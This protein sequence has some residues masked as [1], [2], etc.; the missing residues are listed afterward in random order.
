MQW[1]LRKRVGR[2]KASG[3]QVLRKT[4]LLV[5]SLEER[6]VPTGTWTTLA[7]P[8]P[9]GDG[10]GLMLLQSDGT[11][12]VQGGYDF[13]SSA[14]YKLTPDSTGS[15]LK[16]SWSRLASMHTER[17]DYA[18]NVLP[19]GR[20]FVLGGEYSDPSGDL[21]LTN[22]GEIYDPVA[23]TWTSIP[24][25]PQPVFGDDP[26]EVLPNGQVLVGYKLGPETFLYDPAS[27]TWSATG[28][29]LHND[30]SREE[31]WVKLP[32]DSILSYD[33]TSSLV[34]GTGHAQRY[35]PSLG[36]WVDAG[37]VPVPLSAASVAGDSAGHEIGPA[38]LL[39][40]GRVFCLGASGDTAFYTPPANPTDPGSWVAGPDIPNSLASNDAGG[41][42]LPNGDVL[43]IATDLAGNPRAVLEFNPIASTYTDVTPHNNFPVG[44][45]SKMLVLPTGQ[46]VMANG[47]GQIDVFTPDSGPNPAW[48][49]AIS[50]I[51]DNGNNTFTL[52]GT[53][54]NG[55]S[56]GA[57]FGDDAEMSTNYP[58][59][60][61]TD[62]NG[63]VSYARTYNW[64]STGVATGS[65]PVS[66]QF[67]LPAGAAPGPYLVSVITNGI[68]SAPV[69]DVLMD[70]ANTSLALQ[71]DA[72]D[73]SSVDV[74]NDGSLL[75]EF[76]VSSFTS[77]LVTGSN[78]DNTIAINTSFSG[79]PVVVEE[80]TGHDTIAVGNGDLSSIR[81]SISINGGASVSLGLNDQSFADART[82]KING[83]TI[84]WG[85]AT[86][87]YAG[88]GSVIVN[89]GTGGNTFDPL[90]T[91]AA[92]AV[93]IVGGGSSDT[94][95]GSN[96]G[97]TF[98]ITGSNAGTLNG[99]AYGSGVDFSQVGNLTAGSG[100]DTFR[101]ADGASLSGSIVG[102]SSDT[103]DYTLYRSS[104][105]VDLQ[106]GFAT[107]VGGSVSGV[108]TVFGGSGTPAA[109]GAY[110]LLI[111]KGGDTLYGGY[112]RPSILVAGA[113]AGTLVGG[114][115]SPSGAGR[116]DILIAGSTTYDTEAGLSTWQQIA[117]YWAGSGNYS[118]KVA[119]LLSGTDVP[120]LDAT[121]VTGNGGG[122]TLIG[123]YSQLALLYTDGTD[124][125]ADFAT[126]SQQVRITP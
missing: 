108:A 55:L 114:G 67:T 19:D 18:S 87:N 78:A 34:T 50:S 73:P 101:F 66:V 11:V 14:W 60:C 1:L 38:F 72:K 42:L 70:T 84:A 3:P 53:Q 107:G 43:F 117:A 45:G 52:A 75:G 63:N 49:P 82:F 47:S 111:G 51:S 32:D 40:D 7:N 24:N 92:T 90:A 80:G 71:L 9:G 110:N 22:T 57:S 103:L 23:N 16:G 96:A 5:E 89:G 98:A 29:K 106:T 115:Y 79:V 31:T 123:Y 56:E 113:S 59:I 119:N 81:G 39:P 12:M 77:I 102:G 121:V 27:N 6:A 17:V 91:S 94:L 62:A 58:I 100:G 69:L 93:K 33:I 54:L 2:K 68:S 88:L 13:V 76:P 97:N 41:A 64:S 44:Y 21:N 122:N 86:V 99:N 104:V 118:T 74:M 20:V 95:S 10:A 15:Y 36:Q 35:I 48:R 83:S 28:S 61:L 116:Q 4:Q 46:V 26:S 109:S 126:N 30:P 125:I 124:T 85:G 8:L 112:L 37:T 120:I 105:L 65:T 25:F